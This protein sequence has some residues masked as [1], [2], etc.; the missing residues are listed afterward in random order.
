MRTEC[1]EKTLKVPRDG[2]AGA[3]KR[4]VSRNVSQE[5]FSTEFHLQLQGTPLKKLENRLAK[6][7]SQLNLLGHDAWHHLIALSIS[8]SFDKGLSRVRYRGSGY[9]G[10]REFGAVWI[11]PIARKLRRTRSAAIA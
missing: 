4:E 5:M 8:D 6:A 2:Q 9:C 10:C 7:I 11:W 3:R 1:N